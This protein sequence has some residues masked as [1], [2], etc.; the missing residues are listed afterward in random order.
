MSPITISCIAGNFS[1]ITCIALTDKF[2]YYGTEA[3]TVEIFYL[4]EWTLLSGS[5]LRLDSSIKALYPNHNGTRVI[6]V[7]STNQVYLYN[8]INGNFC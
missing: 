8:P 7:D 2:L 4:I 1:R 3:G 5:E 6:I